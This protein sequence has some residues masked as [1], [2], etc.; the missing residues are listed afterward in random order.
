M[1]KQIQLQIRKLRRKQG[2]TQKELAKQLQVSFQTVSKWENGVTLPDITYL[3]KLA[4]IFGVSSDVL[5]GIQPLDPQEKWRRFD[6]YGYWQR[7]MER[8]KQWKSLYWNDDY[9]S[10][11]VKQVWNINTPVNILDFGCGYGFLG[12][13]LLPLLPEGSTY[14]GIDMDDRAIEEAHRIFRDIPGQAH[15]IREDIYQ[16]EPEK[17]YD[18]IIGLYLIC[19]LQ[20]PDI[21]L[22]KMK[23]SLS[24]GGKLILIDSNL[25][26]EQA[27]YYSCIEKEEGLERP[28]FTPVWKNEANHRE[29]DYRMGTKLPGMLKA[30]GLKS[31]QA[32]IS[33]KVIIYD[34]EDE[35]KKEQNEVFRYVH[36]NTDSFKGG[37]LFYLSRGASY[38]EAE[39][40]VDYFKKTKK[41]FDAEQSFA[42][43]AAGLYFVWGELS[44][45]DEKKGGDFDVR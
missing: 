2:I 37:H 10:F 40:Y 24:D 38:T 17:K 39:R 34:S 9:F 16:Y 35:E 41:Y 22:Q 4:D 19:Y 3:P 45:E 31:V 5:L 27:G 1:E 11:L 21:I 12:M 32:R 13:K 18:I 25:E 7:H 15:F 14:T 20:K 8:T 28:D 44:E 36:E 43:I 42:V 33:D 26:V 6:E 23:A 30:I 29:R